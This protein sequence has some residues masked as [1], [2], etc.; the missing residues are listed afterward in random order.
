MLVSNLDRTVFQAIHFLLPHTSETELLYYLIH[1]SPQG[2]SI[3]GGALHRVVGE[4]PE[5]VRPRFGSA[6]SVDATSSATSVAARAA[7]T[8][9]TTHKPA[10]GAIQPHVRVY[11]TGSSSNALATNGYRVSS[12]VLPEVRL[13]AA[14]T[15]VGSRGDTWPPL[16]PAGFKAESD[17][18]SILASMEEGR[19][20]EDENEDEDDAAAR[21]MGWDHGRGSGSRFSGFVDGN[22]GA[23]SPGGGGRLP[24]P[25]YKADRTTSS[26]E[27]TLLPS[28]LVP[29][30][31]RRCP[32]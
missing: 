26:Q 20:D 7:T 16:E 1:C 27:L 23:G 8:V 17:E 11:Q 25:P 5:K 10:P 12:A 2:V 22:G 30:P 31:R 9:R 3:I 29:G 21:G 14:G 15:G 24:P 19:F 6:S 13:G 4:R 28:W 32:W 18:G